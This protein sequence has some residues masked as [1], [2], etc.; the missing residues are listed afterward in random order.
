MAVTLINT[1]HHREMIRPGLKTRLGLIFDQQPLVRL[2]FQVSIGV[3]E[4]VFPSIPL[5]GIPLQK[6]EGQ[7]TNEQIKAYQERVGSTEE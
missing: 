6:Y 1:P 2:P 4:G 3:Y 5:P 7:A